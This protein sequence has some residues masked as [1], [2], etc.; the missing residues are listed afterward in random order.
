MS[1]IADLTR[2]IR[3]FAERRDWG[4]YHTPKN[5][6]MA[7]CGEAGE[8]AAEFQW[9]TTEEANNI[10][11]DKKHEV[12]LEIADVAIYLLRL[13]DVLEIN[14]ASAIINKIEI[15]EGRFPVAK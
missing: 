2:L 6:A 12:S 8:L 4:I 14:I 11:A 1:E 3:D 15:N 5:L 7:I 10:S 13:S 9:L